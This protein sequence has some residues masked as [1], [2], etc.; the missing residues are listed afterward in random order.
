LATLPALYWMLPLQINFLAVA[1][2]LLATAV[3]INYP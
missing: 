3:A 2:A 1:M